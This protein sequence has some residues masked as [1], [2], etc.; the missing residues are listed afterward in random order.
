MIYFD[1]AWTVVS[2]QDVTA[3][4]CM[5]MAALQLIGR[6]VNDGAV[7]SGHRCALDVIA[8]MRHATSAAEFTCALLRPESEV[9]EA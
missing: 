3:T 7:V 2:K 9:L 6:R 8:L 1:R 5:V 4:G